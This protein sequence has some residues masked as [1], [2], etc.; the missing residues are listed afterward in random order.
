M[1]KN[2][3]KS[4]KQQH[5]IESPLPEESCFVSVRP[6]NAL[7]EGTGGAL[8][9]SPAHVDERQL[10]QISQLKHGREDIIEQ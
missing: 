6:E 2:D 4:D 1:S 9:F 10:V 8:A 3:K 5:D 7:T